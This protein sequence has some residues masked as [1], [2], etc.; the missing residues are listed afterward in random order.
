MLSSAA[1]T[2]DH[3]DDLLLR[4]A[5][6]E[7]AAAR[8]GA[9][10]SFL[11]EERHRFADRRA[12]NPERLARLALV[13]ADLVPMRI[14]VRIHDRLLQRRVRLVAQARIGGDRL[15]GERGG[16]AW[17]RASTCLVSVFPIVWYTICQNSKNSKPG[18]G[19][20]QPSTRTEDTMDRLATKPAGKTATTARRHAENRRRRRDQ[21]PTARNRRLSARHRCPQAQ[22]HRYDLRPAR[23]PDHRPHAQVAGRRACA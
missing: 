6:D 18:V 5:H 21:S 20:T 3:L 16:G 8:H 22:R 9:Q 14:D 7:A 11:L 10:E 19:L 23:H 12:G 1:H 4:L 15:Q 2:L 17:G 13:Q